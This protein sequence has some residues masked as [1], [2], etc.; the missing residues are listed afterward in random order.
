MTPG[1]DAN[2]EAQY[3]YWDHV[4]YLVSLAE[5][6]GIYV[7][8]IPA[9]YDHYRAGLLVLVKVPRRAATGRLLLGCGHRQQ[10]GGY[11]CCAHRSNLPHHP[12]FLR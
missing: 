2:D 1:S 4:D 7:G 12:T 5:A 11:D 10:R 6:K 9:W 3:D 8:L